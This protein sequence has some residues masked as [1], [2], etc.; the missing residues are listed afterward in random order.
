MWEPLNIRVPAG[1]I[2]TSC[3]V[4]LSDYPYDKQTCDIY[5]GSWS[6]SQEH[7]NITTLGTIMIM[8]VMESILHWVSLLHLRVRIGLVW[9]SLCSLNESKQLS[10]DHMQLTPE[11]FNGDE[12]PSDPSDQM[13]ST[14]K[15]WQLVN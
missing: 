1:S 9:S 8:G 2:R 14:E 15:E 13:K 5:F 3:D 12:A 7:I 4:D 10:S 11:E 6:H